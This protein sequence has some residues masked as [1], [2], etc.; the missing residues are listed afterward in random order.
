MTDEKLASLRKEYS[1][2]TLDEKSVAADPFVQFRKWFDES[3]AAKVDEANAM[4]LATVDTKSRPSTRVVLLKD[5]DAR[6]FIFFTNYKSK[7]A[8]DIKENLNAALNFFWPALERQVRIEGKLEKVSAEESD[9]YFSIRPAGSKIGAWASP[10]SEEIP[11][12]A[13]LEAQVKKY[14]EKFAEHE[15]PR[16]K[17]WGGYRLI[18]RRI[19]F[20]QGRESRLHDRILYSKS[21]KS[22]WKIARLAP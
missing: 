17:H 2:A 8:E 1:Q 16:P 18:P 19:E 22:L 6:S 21:K 11:G 5:F 12:R 10:Q 3:L 4:T 15:I 13:W 14:I 9:E 20:W 7:K